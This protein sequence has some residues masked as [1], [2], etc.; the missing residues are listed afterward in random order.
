MVTLTCP[1]P[2]GLRPGDILEAVVRADPASIETPAGWMFAE[3]APDGA[4]F[5]RTIDGSESTMWAVTADEPIEI[6]LRKK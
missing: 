5:V 6:E 2:V 3:V 1:I 4:R